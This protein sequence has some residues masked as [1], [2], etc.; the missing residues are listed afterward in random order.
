MLLLLLCVCVCVYVGVAA[1]P[2]SVSYF[3]LG[4]NIYFIQ[5]CVMLPVG[6]LGSQAGT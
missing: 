6:I 5:V 3:D 1:C 4:K 2:N